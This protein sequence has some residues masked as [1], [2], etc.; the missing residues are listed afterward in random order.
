[1]SQFQLRE[2]QVECLESSVE[3]RAR[4]IN[5][6]MWVLG[7][8]SGKTE[9][10]SRIPEYHENALPMLVLA[11]REE[12]LEQAKTKLLGA[13]PDLKVEIEM[14]AQYASDS[15][16]VVCASVA[17]LGRTGSPRIERFPKDHFKT[18]VVDECHHSSSTTYRNVLD[19]FEGAFRVGVTAT[20]KRTDNVRL[21]D[22]FQ[23]IIFEK[24]MLSL[25]NEGYLSKPISYRFNSS[26][27]LSD[28]NVNAGD[29]A[30]G[31][32][33]EVVNVEARHIVAVEAFEKIAEEIGREPSTV[34]FC[35]DV[36]HA[37]DLAEYFT[38]KGYPAKA[39]SG[40]SEDREEI[41]AGHKADEFKVLT[42]CMI[43]VEGYDDPGIEAIIMARPTK[44]NIYYSQAVGRGA[45]LDGRDNKFYVI[46]IVDAS[47]G[48]RP[49]SVLSLMGLPPEFEANGEEVTEAI[50]KF[51]AL[52][53]QSPSSAVTVTSLAD[54]NAAWEKIDIFTPPPPNPALLE[55]SKL[56]WMEMGDEYVIN[57]T[58]KDRLTI[59]QD[60]LGIYRVF[61]NGKSRAKGT[62]LAKAFAYADNLI[63]TEMSEQV[64]LLDTEAGWRSDP[65]TEKQIKILK[66][67][68]VPYEH[69]S[70]GE[71]SQILDEIFKANP[72]PEKPK[73][74]QNKIAAQKSGRIKF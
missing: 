34:V 46:D 12:L 31:Q 60:Q 43:A 23:E 27:D 51:T 35:T 5:H 56:L 53:D 57:A 45:R 72:R 7:T 64:K 33:S 39:I 55:Y 69:L 17:T 62:T 48:S 19:Y 21:D 3:A 54:I 13:N 9:M 16:D 22:V 11:H 47:R 1:M 10:F 73:W 44:S 42:N 70:K 24:N 38:S 29:Y 36:A 37:E 49:I 74:L 52:K 18:V 30:I 41:I 40:M 32:L 8:G 50:A 6:Q 59:E 2:Y 15:A 20:P 61:H 67:N 4:G 68:S 65:P 26:V 63:R 58:D 14:G 25:I 71:A 28:V 66:K